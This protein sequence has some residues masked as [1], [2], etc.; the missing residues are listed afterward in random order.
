MAFNLLAKLW[1]GAEQS[2]NMDSRD[3]GSEQKPTLR[4]QD[5]ESRGPEENRAGRPRKWYDRSERFY[6]VLWLIFAV[7]TIAI[8][9]RRGGL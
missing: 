5:I 9:I 1:R 8:L 7:L 2:M 3:E 4:P 6:V